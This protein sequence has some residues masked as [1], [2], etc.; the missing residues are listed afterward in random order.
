MLTACVFILTYSSTSAGFKLQTQLIKLLDV[1]E[2][3]Q[4]KI[5]ILWQEWRKHLTA[6]LFEEHWLIEFLLE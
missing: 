1:I 6:T 4:V 3:V 5:V 2:W